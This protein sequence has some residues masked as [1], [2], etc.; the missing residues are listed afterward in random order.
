MSLAMGQYSREVAQNGRRYF[1]NLMREMNSLRE[2]E[3][4]KEFERLN[5]MENKLKNL[6]LKFQK[7]KCPHLVRQVPQFRNL[8]N[9]SGTFL[10]I[11]HL[12]ILRSVRCRSLPKQIHEIFAS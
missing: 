8:W 5:S 12:Q 4:R 3:Q 6:Q 7:V 10:Q 1:L 11:L 2:E 9:F